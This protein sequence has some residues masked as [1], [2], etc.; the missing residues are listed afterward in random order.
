MEVTRAHPAVTLTL[1][2]ERPN[3]G[4]RTPKYKALSEPQEFPNWV[5][6]RAVVDEM[7]GTERFLAP[8]NTAETNRSKAVLI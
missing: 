8:A 1:G 5:E 3:V 6:V 2:L 4:P 7:H